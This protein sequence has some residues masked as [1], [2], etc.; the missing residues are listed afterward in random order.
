[1]STDQAFEGA[2][3]PGYA[4]QPPNHMIDYSFLYLGHSL[5]S[6]SSGIP[7]DLPTLLSSLPVLN[8]TDAAVSP[9]LVILCHKL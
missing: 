8:D 9:I 4:Q 2:L 5:D 3:H 7:F 1:M 6:T